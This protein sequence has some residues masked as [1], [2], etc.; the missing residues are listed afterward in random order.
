M[1]ISEASKEAYNSNSHLYKNVNTIK[2]KLSETYTTLKYLQNSSTSP[3]SDLKILDLGCGGGEIMYEVL[4]SGSLFVSG[5]DISESMLS[6]A[7]SLLQE[8]PNSS[9]SFQICNAFE[10]GLL[11]TLYN[12]IIFDNIIANC[13]S[14]M[15]KMCRS[16]KNSF[17]HVKYC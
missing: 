9:Y 17:Y 7:S 16:C 6:N 12:D 11:Q 5:L 3:A 4:T 14:I 15:L 8:F 2:K 1:N 13:L 10:L